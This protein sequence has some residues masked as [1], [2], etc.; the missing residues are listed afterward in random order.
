M[1]SHIF[2][3]TSAIYGY[4]NLKDPAHNRIKNFIDNFKGRLLITNYIFDEIITLILY[5]LGHKTASTAGNILLNSPQIINYRITEND[6]KEGW[7]L[8]VQRYDKEYS[9][10][11]CTSFIIMKKLNIEK[12]LST[13]KHFRQEGFEI[14]IQE[15]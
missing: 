11:D 9:F 5:R 1:K 15:D 4:I 8:F 3:D 13:D 10:T 2:F 14:V 6:E 7:K 12:C